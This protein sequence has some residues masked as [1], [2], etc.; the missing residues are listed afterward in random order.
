[1]RVRRS[2]GDEMATSGLSGLSV[3][4]IRFRFR[5]EHRWLSGSMSTVQRRLV[6]VLNGEGSGG[7]VSA[8]EVSAQGWLDAGGAASYPSVNVNTAAVLYAVPVEDGDGPRGDPHARIKKRP[9]RVRVGIGPFEIVGDTYLVEQSNLR[10]VLALARPRFIVVGK[11][12]VRRIDDPDFV[13]E[14]Q[15]LLVN[16]KRLD[17]I[18]PEPSRDAR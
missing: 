13:E 2:V 11:A 15:V 9:E 6:D 16:R 7:I 12:V 3:Q 1:V 18:V 10:D 14:H 8:E 5:T 4:R 17:F